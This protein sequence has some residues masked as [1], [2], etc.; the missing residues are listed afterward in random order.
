MLARARAGRLTAVISIACVIAACDRTASVERSGVTDDDTPEELAA[1]VDELM[2]RLERLSGLDRTAAVRV[3]AQ[4]PAAV[5]RYVEQRLQQEMPPERLAGI[6]AAYVVLGLIPDT[7]DLRALLL[8]LYNEQVLG[9]YDP[10]TRTLYVLD[11]VTDDAL[12]PVLAHEL[13]HALQDQHTN[14]DSLISRE[15]GNDRQAAAHAAMEGHAVVVMFASLAEQD[16][17]RRIDPIALASPWRE[18]ERALDAQPEQ[19]PV[20]RRAPAVVRETL[21]FPYIA[22]SDFVHT[23][24]SHYRGAARYPAPIDSLLPQSTQQVLEPLQHF[25]RRRTDPIELQFDGLAGDSSVL[26]ENT[27]GQLETGIFLGHYL[28]AEARA[29]ASGWRGDRYVVVR[30]GDAH[31][32]LWF[33]VWDSPATAQRF[34]TR[35][36]SVADRRPARSATVEVLELNGHAAIRVLDLPAAAPPLLRERLQ[37]VAVRVRSS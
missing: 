35:I 29:A 13:V 27:L 26:H 21:L 31:G 11:T 28:G 18:V 1:L 7:L 15:R 9:Y 6:R 20:L 14:L 33:S 25:I 5:R 19:F 12:G 4:D 16:S 8:E 17:G 23:L 2:P 37:R 24:W 32:L 36:R 30:D 10:R 34:A 3:R 22:G